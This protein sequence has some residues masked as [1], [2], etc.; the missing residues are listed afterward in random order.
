MVAIKAKEKEDFHPSRYTL[1]ICIEFRGMNDN[2]MSVVC[3][4]SSMYTIGDVRV[5]NLMFM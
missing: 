2:I 4:Y 1:C 5:A 3:T